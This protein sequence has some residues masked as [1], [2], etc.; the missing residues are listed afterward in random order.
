MN[1]QRIKRIRKNKYRLNLLL[2]GPPG[3]GKSSSGN[4]FYRI[5]TEDAT[6]LPQETA[7]NKKGTQFYR[8]VP[9]LEEKANIRLF[10]A[11]GLT[12]WGDVP[13]VEKMLDGLRED[14]KSEDWEKELERKDV[15]VD[16][17]I[18]FVIVV[19]SALELEQSGWYRSVRW[20]PTFLPDDV[21][22][23]IRTKT[24]FDPFILITHTKE[25]KCSEEDYKKCVGKRV[26]DSQIRFVDNY[27]TTGKPNN[28]KM[29]TIFA[30]VLVTIIERVKYLN[31]QK[32]KYQKKDAEKSPPKRKEQNRKHENH[33]S[34]ESEYDPKYKR[35]S[36]DTEYYQTSE[37]YKK[38][39][40]TSED[41]TEKESEI[42]KK[43]GTK[44]E[45]SDA[46]DDSH[47]YIKKKRKK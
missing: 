16:N 4:S 45:K 21:T 12:Q 23:T 34:N 42:Y 9:E 37:E 2:L 15:D 39:Y 28:I 11:P 5:V 25:M 30:E 36:R 19:L 13:T 47:Q 26:P 3:H 29:D 14:Y 43:R 8:T 40:E 32:I 41:T 44:E 10:D 24:G 17:K 31:K 18:D 1:L 22:K 7:K 33:Q 27:I 20:Q 38:R 46:T 6:Y 35:Q